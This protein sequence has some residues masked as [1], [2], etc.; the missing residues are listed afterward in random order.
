MN[1]FIPTPL[2]TVLLA[3]VLG[4]SL[5]PFYATAGLQEGA[6][7]YVAGDQATA[8]REFEPLALQGVEGAINGIYFLAQDGNTEAWDTMKRLH[9]N[10][11][12]SGEAERWY[13][14]TV[15][16]RKRVEEEAAA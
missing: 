9:E 11:Q 1:R 8:L 10:R 12:L 6:M 4:C 5:L 16:E 13:V 14:N 2:R 3:S 7:A 15:A